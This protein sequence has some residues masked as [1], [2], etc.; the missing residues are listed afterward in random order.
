M[1]TRVTEAVNYFD[2][3]MRNLQAFRVYVAD[4]IVDLANFIRPNSPDNGEEKG[5]V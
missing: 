4:R 1:P 5:E 2:T 3:F